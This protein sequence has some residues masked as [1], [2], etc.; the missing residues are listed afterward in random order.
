MTSQKIIEV[1][2]EEAMKRFLYLYKMEKLPYK[3]VGKARWFVTDGSCAALVEVSKDKARIKGTVTA[4]ELRGQGYGAAMLQ[5]LIQEAKSA[6]YK[7][8]ES[9]AKNPKWY[10]ENGFRTVRQ[11]KWGVTVVTMDISS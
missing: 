3:E 2:H 8:I 4:P 1:T 9:F 6:G 11:T 7:V 5:H 10:L